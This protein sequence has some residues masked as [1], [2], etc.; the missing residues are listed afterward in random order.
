LKNDFARFAILLKMPYASLGDKFVAAKMKIS[1]EWYKWQTVI[2]VLQSIGRTVRHDE[3]WCVTYILDAC[4]SDLIQSSRNSF[5]TEFYE[6]LK[7]ISD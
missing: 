4:L 7:V 2:E 1:P 6:R 3:D 5:P